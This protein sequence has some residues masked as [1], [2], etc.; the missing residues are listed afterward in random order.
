[1]ILLMALSRYIKGLYNDQD[2]F[3]SCRN[4]RLHQ[5]GDTAPVILTPFFSIPTFLKHP[6]FKHH[7]YAHHHKSYLCSTYAL[8][9][10]HLIQR[11]MQVWTS[12]KNV[13][14]TSAALRKYSCAQLNRVTERFYSKIATF[15]WP[16]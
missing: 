4:I 7:L 14:N 16:I 12:L 2:H 8:D 5:S 9:T 10:Y 6:L 15:E 3:L 1:M 13:T 11:L